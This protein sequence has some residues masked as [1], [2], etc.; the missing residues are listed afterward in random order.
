M[1]E[2]YLKFYNKFIR[3]SKT[4]SDGRVDLNGALKRKN[5]GMDNSNRTSHS[6]VGHSIGSSGKTFKKTPGQR[7]SRTGLQKKLMHQTN[8][9]SHSRIMGS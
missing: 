7:N 5:Y 9:L 8:P 3:H 2:K 4:V 1:E 6:N